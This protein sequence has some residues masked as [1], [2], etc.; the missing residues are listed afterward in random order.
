M[1]DVGFFELLL[2]SIISLLVL[3]PERLPKAARTVGRWVGKARATVSAFKTDIDRELQLEEMRAKLEEHTKFLEDAK[4]VLDQEKNALS[5][6]ANSIHNDLRKVVGDTEDG[7]PSH[8][9]TEYKPYP[10]DGSDDTLPQQTTGASKPQT[11]VPADDDSYYD[12]PAH[13]PV[14]DDE[15]V[16]VNQYEQAQKV[17]QEI[18][19][20]NSDA[21]PMPEEKENSGESKS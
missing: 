19:Q 6:S 20:S 2:I 11:K 7:E 3:G 8:N 1:F 5:E 4:S 9:N 16:V 12:I 10:E 13:D 21:V 18:E 14:E 15:D 17:K